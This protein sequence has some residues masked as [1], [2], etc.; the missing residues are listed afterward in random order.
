MG[1]FF[2]YKCLGG[3][4]GNFKAV[5][6][7]ELS[8]K[9]QA[10][11]SIVSWSRVEKTYNLKEAR[12]PLEDFTPGPNKKRWLIQEYDKL[13][14]TH[15]ITIT[16]QNKDVMPFQ[17]TVFTAHMDGFEQKQEPCSIGGTDFGVVTFQQIELID[18]DYYARLNHPPESLANI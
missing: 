4:P 9:E 1:S 5:I 8:E 14:T 13:L 17:R 6:V 18:C 12:L 11:F 7:L 3:I 2:S 16:I 15:A 10:G